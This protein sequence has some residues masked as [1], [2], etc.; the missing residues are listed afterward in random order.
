[1]VEDAGMHDSTAFLAREAVSR[2]AQQPDRSVAVLRAIRRS[3][4]RESRA[5][6]GRDVL[7]LAERL[8]DYRAPRWFVYELVHHH[9]TAMSALSGRRLARLG[10]DL[11][12]WVTSIRSVATCSVPHGATAGS[13]MRI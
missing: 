9:A 12:S 6:P 4:S 7:R 13:Q 1:M 5:L 2:L 3:V 8:L 11:A 10:Q